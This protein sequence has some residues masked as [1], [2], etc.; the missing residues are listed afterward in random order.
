[1]SG[2]AFLG[3]GAQLHCTCAALHSPR[4]LLRTRRQL[5]RVH[6]P[7]F[8]TRRRVPNAATC[9]CLAAPYLNSLGAFPVSGDAVSWDWRTVALHLRCTSLAPAAASHAP[10]AVSCRRRLVRTRRRLFGARQRVPKAPT[11]VCPATPYLHSLA[12]CCL[13]SAACLSCRRR[14]SRSA[15]LI[16]RRPSPRFSRPSPRFSRPLLLRRCCLA[17]ASLPSSKDRSG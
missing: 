8:R 13:S 17:A 10:A 16:K 1:M 11:C 4:R 14:S 2:H 15:S 7:L 6:W 12:A 5:F 9:A 3:T